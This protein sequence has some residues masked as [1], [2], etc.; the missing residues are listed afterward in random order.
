M[1]IVVLFEGV[2]INF[3]LVVIWID[4]GKKFWKG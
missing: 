1:C 2:V 4:V 3:S